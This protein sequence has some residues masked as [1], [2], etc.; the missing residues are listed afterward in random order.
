MIAADIEKTKTLSPLD[1][2]EHYILCVD[3]DAN[4]LKSI[5]FILSEKINSLQQTDPWYWFSF[6]DDPLQALEMLKEILEDGQSVAMVI[7]DQKMPQM[8]GTDFLAEVSKLSPHSMRVLLTGYAGLESAIEAINRKILDKYLTKPIEDEKDFILSIQHLL[9]IHQMN[10]QLRQTEDKIRHLAYHDSLT[11]L[12]NR[13][14][15]KERLEQTLDV[16]RRYDRPM[17]VLF[18]DLDNFKRIND[19]LGHSMGDLLLQTVA[20]RLVSAIRTSDYVIQGNPEPNGRQVARLGGDEFT[21]LLS[22]IKTST[23]AAVVS[24]RILETLSHPFLLGNQEVTI[25]PS[26]GISVFPD[27]GEDV[28]TLLK[29]ADMAM[30]HAKKSGKNN[31]RFYNKS[32]GEAA[33]KRLVMEGQLRRALERGEFSLQYQPQVDIADRSISG[34]EALLRWNNEELG[35]IPPSMFISLMEE[36]GLIIPIGEW[37][38]RTACAQTRAWQNAKVAIPRVS[39]NLSAL[40]F[41]QPNLVKLI[42][43]ILQE[44]G[45]EADCL[46]LEITESML[47]EDSGEALSTLHALKAMG[48]RLAIDDFG[49]GYS[50]LSYLK[51]LPIDRLKI[52]QSFVHNIGVDPKDAAII[53]AI[54]TMAESMELAVVAEGVETDAQLA[55]LEARHCHEMQGYL[56]CRPVSPEDITHALEK[57]TE[58]QCLTDNS[59]A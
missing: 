23:D 30:Y 38:L 29:N 40:Q 44:S 56:F 10:D 49:T 46:E 15:F 6:L 37:V 24:A 52:D 17:A 20:E 25:T 51:R 8:K 14:A 16:A 4:F 3:D 1:Q 35:L 11:R 39:V 47:M 43:Q 33:L 41:K 21:V 42:A 27:D 57:V 19:T 50:S 18:L 9:Q 45:L 28:D 59:P 26:I 5:G 34:V 7:S 22:E 12:P 58:N 2:E 54:I 13:E 32:M 55:F 31:F 53:T 48:V 36:T